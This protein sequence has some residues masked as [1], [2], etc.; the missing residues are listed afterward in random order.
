MF[1]A[2]VM[3][4]TFMLFAVM[5][6]ATFML[7]AVVMVAT[8]MLFVVVMVMAFMFFAVVMVATFMLFAV[9]A[10]GFSLVPQAFHECRE[11][12]FA[13]NRR[14]KGFPAQFFPRGSHHNGIRIVFA[15]KCNAFGNFG[16][17]HA[18]GATE[19]DGPCMFDLVVEKFAEVFHI[20]PAFF[21]IYHYRIA[22]KFRVFES[23][24]F[25]CPDYVAQLPDSGRFD[26]NAVGMVFFLYPAQSQPEISDQTATDT[27]RIHLRDLNT[28]LF[29]ET[30]VNPDLAEFVFNQDQFFSAVSVGN[31][32]FDQGGFSGAEE[33]GKNVNFCHDNT[34]LGS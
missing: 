26:Q 29:Q 2:V 3:V 9:L 16:I 33:S 11:S 24:A 30:A 22:G 1:F 6:V 13:R 34:S 5:M 12:I 15:E 32:F 28:R 4:A 10:C 19:N 23:G 14:K 17:A 20:H 7:F 27:A 8:F 18:P 25:H 21:G 31:Q